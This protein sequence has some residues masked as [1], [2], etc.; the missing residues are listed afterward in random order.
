MKIADVL[1]KSGNAD[2][3]TV[4]FTGDIIGSRYEF[5]NTKSK[6]FQ[7]FSGYSNFT[8]DR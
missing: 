1:A 4:I 2:F 8:D 5:S 3:Q 7:L 6:D